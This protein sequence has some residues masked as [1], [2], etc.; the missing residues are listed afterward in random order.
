MRM[1]TI[2]QVVPDSLNLYLVYLD[3]EI[4]N[5]PAIHINIPNGYFDHFD[6]LY[7]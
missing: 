1:L 3:P 4:V 5:N 6:Y 7:T 2:Y